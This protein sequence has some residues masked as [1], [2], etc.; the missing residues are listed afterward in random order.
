MRSIF[1]DTE[2]LHM[3]GSTVDGIDYSFD[4]PWQLGLAVACTTEKEEGAR[5]WLGSDAGA[6][7]GYLASADVVIG[8]NHLR[9]DL[10]LVGGEM[11]YQASA[12]APYLE[13]LEP[14]CEALESAEVCFVDM[15]LDVWEAIGGRVKGTGLK[16]LAVHTL[17]KTVGMEGALAPVAWADFRKLDVIRYCADDVQWSREL[18]NHALRTGK[19]RRADERGPGPPPIEF[20]VTWNIRDAAGEILEPFRAWHQRHTPKD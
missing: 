13:P 20:D 7:V 9:F 19:L 3:P 6:L 4:R 15:L 11:E 5:Q 1:I 16:P 2:C 8:F 12:G 18:F 17:G 10:P 14:L